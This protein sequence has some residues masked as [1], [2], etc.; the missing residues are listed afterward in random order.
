[1]IFFLCEIL[2]QN[3]AFFQSFLAWQEPC[4]AKSCIREWVHWIGAH[5]S[6]SGSCLLGSGCSG[7]HRVQIS[8]VPPSLPYFRITCGMIDAFYLW[9]TYGRLTCQP[10]SGPAASSFAIGGFCKSW[11]CLDREGWDAS[12]RLGRS[13]REG[14]VADPRRCA[15]EAPN[16]QK[17]RDVRTITGTITKR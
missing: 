3:L 7:W 6:S 9:G 8:F 12:L 15:V 2:V 17:K 1:M 10:C 4:G 5:C 14:F 16:F 13:N 11:A